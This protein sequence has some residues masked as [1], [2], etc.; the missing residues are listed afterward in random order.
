ML[1]RLILF[2]F[3]SSFDGKV[4]ILLRNGIRAGK[5]NVEAQNRKFI[6]AQFGLNL[7]YGKKSE[8][9]N[10]NHAGQFTLNLCLVRH[11][12]VFFF[13]RRERIVQVFVATITKGGLKYLYL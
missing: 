13:R 2:L 3:F 5:F 11:K 6:I 9:S 12:T 8:Q 1:A 10:D 4:H 7:S